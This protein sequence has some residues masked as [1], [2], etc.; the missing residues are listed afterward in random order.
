MKVGRL[1]PELR[2]SKYGDS[3]QLWSK[4]FL[5]QKRKYVT[6]QSSIDF[7]GLRHT[8]KRVC[9]DGGIDEEVHDLLTGHSSNAIGRRYGE[10]MNV[11][12]LKDAIDRVSYPVSITTWK[13]AS[14]RRLA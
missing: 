8:F 9:R 5:R 7:H 6:D 2:R 12:P 1:F 3:T 11:R 4:W 13:K 14:N 10:G